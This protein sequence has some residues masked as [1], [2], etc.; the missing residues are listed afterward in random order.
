MVD[1][2]SNHA[3]DIIGNTIDMICLNSTQVYIHFG[4]NTYVAMEGQYDLLNNTNNT[5]E[6]YRAPY[7]PM[8]AHKLIDK[9][10]ICSKILRDKSLSIVVEGGITIIIRNND[11]NYESYQ[12]YINGRVIFVA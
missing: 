3:I 9:K 11:T 8:D 1:T 10:V 12:L 7:L 4:K 6:E 2:D 5:C